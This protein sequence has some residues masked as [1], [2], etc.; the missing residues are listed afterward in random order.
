MN[1]DIIYVK[2]ILRYCDDIAEA[3]HTFGSDVED[4]LENIQFQHSCSFELLQIGE[5]V[6]RLSSDFT[7]RYPKTE[8]SNIAKLREH[9]ITQI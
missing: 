1:R 8:W 3:I 9:N 2:D 7:S 5:I 4:F 6:K